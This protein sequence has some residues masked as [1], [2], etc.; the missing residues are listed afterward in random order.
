MARHF[1]HAG[2]GFDRSVTYSC[3]LIR[4]EEAGSVRMLC[5]EVPKWSCII[6]KGHS[7]GRM[8]GSCPGLRSRLRD[9][10]GLQVQPAA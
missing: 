5:C 8:A 7:F 4:G 1:A 2:L 9:G 10:Y 3:G 6:T